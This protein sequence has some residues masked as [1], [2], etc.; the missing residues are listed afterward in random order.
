M[1]NE[2]LLLVALAI[3]AL[4]LR[5]DGSFSDSLYM[6]LSLFAAAI[7]G[8]KVILPIKKAD[9]YV[10]KA[11][12]RIIYA[13]FATLLFYSLLLNGFP[14]LLLGQGFWRISDL[15][16]VFIVGAL[17]LFALS[18]LSRVVRTLRLK[19]V[20]ETK[21]FYIGMVFR[22][23]CF[24]LIIHLPTF[25]PSYRTTPSRNLSVQSSHQQLSSSEVVKL[26]SLVE[27]FRSNNAFQGV[28]VYVKSDDKTYEA[29][30][31][32]I[33]K[34][35]QRRP[36]GNDYYQIAS[37]SKVLTATLLAD[38]LKEGKIDSLTTLAD[39]YDSSNWSGNMGNVSLISL[40]MH[41]SGLARLSPMMDEARLKLFLKPYHFYTEGSFYNDLST[42]SHSDEK[43]FEYSNFGFAVLGHAL[44]KSTGMDYLDGRGLLNNFRVRVATPF[45]MNTIALANEVE[46]NNSVYASSTLSNGKSIP[47]WK[48]AQIAGA[49]TF[50]AT[51]NDLKA[52]VNQYVVDANQDD[53][54]KTYTTWWATN[55]IGIPLPNSK[56][57]QHLGWVEQPLEINE[58]KSVQLFWHNGSTYGNT[59][60]VGFIPET[61]TSIVVLS[62]TQNSVDGLAIKLLKEVL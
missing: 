49:G 26:D 39:I 41:T 34:E 30:G 29:H 43:A 59:S 28:S 53:F 46:G 52:F 44:T 36:N 47:K 9:Q 38:L 19:E 5:F 8:L 16:A 3:S 11:Y 1:F 33:N 60:F 54:G 10:N 37:V 4:Y 12:S 22:I 18:N 27:A 17:S 15:I 40:A 45:G 42:Y 21:P 7:F 32:I 31:G 61:Q 2:W 20:D 13:L 57:V 35:L 25:A 62:N 58:N 51:L 55:Y 48:N 50:I 56:R 6:V 24:I 14:R 23:S